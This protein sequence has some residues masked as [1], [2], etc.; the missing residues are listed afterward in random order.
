MI[1]ATLSL[2]MDVN[3]VLNFKQPFSIPILI[4]YICDMKLIAKL[5]LFVFIT[6]LST[7]TIISLIEKSTDTSYFYSTSEEEQ[8]HKEVKAE[9]KLELAYT[10]ALF[11]SNTSSLIQ[12]ENLSKH[13]NIAATIFIPPPEQV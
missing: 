13:D 1:C 11:S 9:L 10:L 8:V 2:N 12:S 3:F 5:F 6:F 4:S 7:P